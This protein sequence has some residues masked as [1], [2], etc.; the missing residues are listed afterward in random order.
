MPHQIGVTIRAPVAAERVTELRQ[1][2]AEAGKKGLGEAPF[3][4]ADCRGLHFARFYLLE[5]TADLAGRPIPASLVFMSEVDAP[6]RRHL[7]DLADVAKEGIDQAFQHC[8]GYPGPV[9]RRRRRIAWLRRH[10]A[11]PNGASP[12]PFFAVSASQ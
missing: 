9:G 12:R 3:G 5:E 6:L 8:P 10:R 7:A 2:L 4:F 1:W 11:K